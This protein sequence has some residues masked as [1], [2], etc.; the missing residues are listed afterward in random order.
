MGQADAGFRRVL[1]L[2]DLVYLNVSAIVGFRWLSTAAQMGP[3]S[4]TLWLL[5]AALFFIPYGLVVAE[6]NASL[7]GSGG[8][9]LWS[10]AAF[11]ELHGFISGWCYLVTNLVFLPSLLLFT[12]GSFFLIGGDAWHG[13]GDNPWY[14]G[15]FCVALLWCTTVLNI[16][17]LDRAKWLPN[18][19]AYGTWLIFALLIVGG[20][21]AFV[22]VGS[23]VPLAAPA[24]LPELTAPATVANLAT[25][26]LAFAGLEIGT[27]M[28]DEIR[29]PRR[30]VPRALLLSAVMITVLYVAGTATLLIAV[31]PGKVDIVTG[32][33]QALAEVGRAARLPEIGRFAAL[34]LVASNLG[35]LGAWISANARLP[36][37]MGLHHQMPR[38]LGRLHP[39][40]G[41]PH[42]ALVVQAL[43]A[44]LLMLLSVAGA[45][46]RQAIGVLTDMTL[47]LYFIPLLYMFAAL[48]VLRARGRAG[49]HGAFRV[50]G[51]LPTA[52]LVAGSA[53]AVT[54]GAIVLSLVPPRDGSD[55]RLFLLKVVG[56]SLL[57]LAIGLLFYFRSALQASSTNSE[58][59]R[60][61][62]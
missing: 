30:T 43:I 11:G 36:F 15:T 24:L 37:A 17:G 38:A 57:L 22:R 32:I 19:G 20:I 5:A 1:G 59:S 2:R 29:D 42:V 4:L 10:R 41:T 23:A 27:V 45:T 39:R 34:V 54:F 35:G 18:I 62:K 53:F 13:L 12:A 58:R 8:P 46:V 6:L 26:A 61:G 25:I 3:S 31:P 49:A 7:P 51:G 9:Y 56:G 52:C 44:S 14:A 33:P 28:G 48:P 60:P 50:P 40:W 21:V 16:V 55:P 47:I